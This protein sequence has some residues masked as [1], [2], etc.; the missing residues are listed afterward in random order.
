MDD[1]AEQ[2]QNRETVKRL[3]T[4]LEGRAA[5]IW[6]TVAPAGS[7]EPRTHESSFA[8]ARRS[9]PVLATVMV[10]VAALAVAAVFAVFVQLGTNERAA[11]Q[12]ALLAR[13]A[14]LDRSALTPGSMLACVD[15]TAGETVGDGCEKT[16]F[17]SAQNAA[18]AV[19]YVAARID[20]L[21][22]AHRLA[23][24]GDPAVLTALASARRAIALDRYGIAAH[25]LAQRDDCTAIHC[26]FFATIGD[27]YALKANLKAQLFDQYVSRHAVDWGKPKPVS[28]PAE[29]VA[30][31]A[32]AP[33]PLASAA[34]LP[35]KPRPGEHWDFPS[36]DSIPPVSI[37]D[38]EPKLSKEAAERLDAAA[39]KAKAAKN[40]AAN[41]AA[42]EA[43]A[44]EAQTKEAQKKKPQAPG[45]PLQLMH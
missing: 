34:P 21:R 11:E 10:F 8:R 14:A 12:R 30:S 9:R 40:S 20:L 4:Q 16:V 32:P 28:K 44:K 3:I 23:D 19:A 42:S 6:P 39:A 37:M 45:A 17:A 26:A 13:A 15:G 2:R 33:T 1:I 35:A 27:V 5:T 43:L 18:T 25:V 36:A 38:P 7:E 22:E 31:A 29:P 41:A 24:R